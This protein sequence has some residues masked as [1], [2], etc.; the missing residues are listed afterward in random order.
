MDE[1]DRALMAEWLADQIRFIAALDAQPLLRADACVVLCGEDAEP[2]VQFGAGVMMHGGADVIVLSGGV[3]NPPAKYGADQMRGPLYGA[4][5]SPTRV[6][7]D[8]RSQNTWEQAHEVIKMARDRKWRRILVV[9]SPYHTYRA[10]L[11]FVRALMEEELADEL[12]VM[13]AGASQTSW[14]ESPAGVQKSR[15]DLLDDEWRKIQEYESHV[16]SY[17][18]GVEYL[19]RWSGK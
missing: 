17:S 13:V 11:T 15:L 5:V 18:D 7:V 6:L 19:K 1:E 8:D 14:W 3:H 10:F 9:A 12:H 2:G 4:G 16:T